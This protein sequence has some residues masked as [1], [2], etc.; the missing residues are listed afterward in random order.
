MEGVRKKLFS[1]QA[2]HLGIIFSMMMSFL[3]PAVSASAY[4]N[5]FASKPEA[6]EYIVKT[7]PAK[8]I[9]S[10]SVEKQIDNLDLDIISADSNTLLVKADNIQDIQN[11]NNIKSNPDIEYI[12][13]N[14]ILKASETALD[15]EQAVQPDANTEELAAVNGGHDVIQEEDPNSG[16][17]PSETENDAIKLENNPPENE[18]PL[19]DTESTTE[20]P[21]QETSPEPSN[22][23]QD[24]QQPVEVPQEEEVIPEELPQQNT[25]NSVDTYKYD[26]WG[27][28]MVNADSAWEQLPSEG[29]SKVTI[30]VIDSGVDYNHSDL[31]GVVDQTNGKDY[32]NNDDDAMD[33]FGHG[34]HVAG[35]IAAEMNNGGIVGVAA[36]TSVKILPLKVL[37]SRGEGT[38]FNI[39]LAIKDAVDRGADIINLSLGGPGYSKTLEEAVNYAINHNVLV[40]AA[41][42]NDY[43][44][45]SYYTPA[46]LPGVLTVGSIDESQDK[47]SFSNYGEELEIVAPGERV[48]STFPAALIGNMSQDNY[49][50]ENDSYYVFEDGTSM[51]T[52]FVSGVAALLKAND[53]SLSARDIMHRLTLTANDLGSFG[54]DKEYGYGLVD[55][56]A[57]LTANTLPDPAQLTIS[58]PKQEQ[59]IWGKVDVTFEAIGLANGEAINLS[60]LKDEVT[61]KTETINYD[62]TK[63]IYN[64][65]WDT[66]LLENG[67]YTLKVESSTQ[68]GTAGPLQDSVYVEVRNETMNGLQLTVKNP[69][70]TPAA[71]AMVAVVHH[72]YWDGIGEVDGPYYPYPIDD[73]Y[74]WS[75]IVYDG[76]TDQY[77]HVRIPGA[78]ATDGN[79][80]EV[81]VLS[82]DDN[83]IPV[84]YHKVLEGPT[85]Q[86]IDGSN[87][88]KV[89]FNVEDRATNPIQ[90]ADIILTFEKGK[91]IAG[92]PIPIGMTND[93]GEL[94]A[95]IEKDSYVFET[96]TEQAEDGNMYILKTPVTEIGA[97]EQENQDITFDSQST[98]ELNVDLSDESYTSVDMY[99]DHEGYGLT[100][101]KTNSTKVFVSEG[102]YYPSLDLNVQD[103]DRNW[104]YYFDRKEPVVVQKNE[105]VTLQVGGSLESEIAVSSDDPEEIEIGDELYRETAIVDQY[106]N[107]LY[108]EE[109]A[110]NVEETT[111]FS[112]L[113]YIGKDKKRHYLKWDP[114]SN[115]AKGVLTS[116][117]YQDWVDYEP[118]LVITKDGEEL[119]RFNDFDLHDSL[120][121]DTDYLNL[122]VGDYKAHFEL[123]AG[124]LGD[125]ISNEVA[126]NVVDGSTPPSTTKT[127]NIIDVDGNNASYAGVSIIKWQT[128]S[129]HDEYGVT[130]NQPNEQHGYYYPVLNTN[131]DEKGNVEIPENIFMDGETYYLL[132]DHY[133]L[134]NEHELF[135]KKVTSLDGFDSI[136]LQ[137][138]LVPVSLIAKDQ[139]QDLVGH[140]AVSFP[141]EE[142]RPITTRSASYL[143]NGAGQIWLTKDQSYNFLFENSYVY[144]YSQPGPIYYLSLKNELITGEKTVTFEGENTVAIDGDFST[145]NNKVIGKR[146][147]LF[148]PIHNYGIGYNMV[149]NKTINV[150]PGTYNLSLN[151]TIEDKEGI[152]G[153]WFDN[154]QQQVND[155][156]TL[157]V[158]DMFTANLS[159]KGQT[160]KP[161][162]ELQGE[163]NFSD[164]YGNRLGEIWKDPIGFDEDYYVLKQTN[165]ISF[166]D[167]KTGE[168]IEPLK[169]QYYSPDDVRPIFN[170]YTPTGKKIAHYPVWYYGYIYEPINDTFAAG[171]H[172]AEIVLAVGPQGV[173]KAEQAFE[174]VTTKVTINE[175][176]LESYTNKTTVQVTGTAPAGTNVDIMNGTKVLTSVKADSEGYFK[177]SVNLGK[178]GIYEIFAKA[179]G[180]ASN[181]VTVH[182]DLTAPSAATVTTSQANNRVQLTWSNTSQDVVKYNIYRMVDGKET[183]IAE[184]LPVTTTQHSDKTVEPGKTYQYVVESVD[185]AGNKTKSS[186][187]SVTTATYQIN[188]VSYTVQ[189]GSRGYAKIGTDLLFTVT[190]TTGQNVNA[191]VTFDTFESE[192]E[193]VSIPLVEEPAGTFKGNFTIMEDIKQIK[194]AKAV[195]FLVEG[196]VDIPQQEKEIFTTPIT[197]GAT[198]KGNVTMGTTTTPVTDATVYISGANDYIF[199]KVS[200]NGEFEIAGLE[201]NKTYQISVYSPTKGWASLQEDLVVTTGSKVVNIPYPLQYDVTIKVVDKDKEKPLKGVWVS[202]QKS[203]TG[204]YYYG[205]GYTNEEGIVTLWNSDETPFTKLK[206]GEYQLSTW[207]NLNYK[208]IDAELS[209]IAISGNELDIDK[210]IAL[211]SLGSGTISGTV[212][213]SGT[214]EG[215]AGATVNA[216]SWQAYNKGL[217]ASF[218]A[219]SDG[220]GNYKF[221]NLPTTTDWVVTFQKPGYKSNTKNSVQVT[222][223][224][225]TSVDMALAPSE[226]IVG[227][228]KKTDGTL[229]GGIQVTAQGPT[230]WYYATTDGQGKFTINGLEAGNYTVST[231]ISSSLGFKNASKNVTAD[232]FADNRTADVGILE[233]AEYGSIEGTVLDTKGNPL[234]YIYVYVY[235]KTSEG[236]E[237]WSQSART[238][239]QGFFKV[240]GL[241]SGKS[242]IVKT[243]NYQGYID[244][245]QEAK[246]TDVVTFV[247][248][249]EAQLNSAFSGEGNGWTVDRTVA[250]P[251]NEIEYTLSYKNNSGVDIEGVNAVF[252]LDSNST[253]TANSMLVNGA[254]G[255]VTTEGNK[256]TVNLGNI[257][258]DGKGVIRFKATIDS[259]LAKDI[260][261]VGNASLTWGGKKVELSPAATQ[262]VLTTINAP[263]IVTTTDETGKIP[264]T[265]YGKAAS[266]SVVSVYDGDKVLGQAAVSGRWWSLQVYLDANSEN[267]EHYLFAQVTKGEMKHSSETITVTY[268]PD[269]PKVTELEVDAGWNGKVKPNPYNDL[270]TFAITE[271]YAIPVKLVFDDN[272]KVS[273]VKISFIGKE[274]NLTL[275][276]GYYTGQVPYGW[277]GFGEHVIELHFTFNGEVYTLPIMEV[278]VLIDPSGYV[279]EGARENRLEGVTSIIEQ[280]VDDTNND[281]RDGKWLQWDAARFGQI[282][283]Q[284]TDKEGKY[285]WDVPQGE[286]RVIF[287]KDGYEKVVSETVNVPPPETQLNVGLFSLAKPEVKQ[288]TPSDAATNIAVST[289]INI[290]FSQLMDEST[291]S[292]D[293][294]ILTNKATE[295]VVAGGTIEGKDGYAGYSTSSSSNPG[296]PTG[297]TLSKTFTYTPSAALQPNTEYE[298]TIRG[299]VKNYNNKQLGEDYSWS[300]K[301]AA[302]SDSGTPTNPPSGG[303]PGGGGP[304]KQPELQVDLK[305]IIQT[306]AKDIK[307]TIAAEK[308]QQGIQ[309]DAE[310]I[311]QLKAKEKN[312]I[313]ESDQYLIHIPSASVPKLGEKSNLQLKIEAK[314][315]LKGQNSA[316]YKGVSNIF[317]FS[318]AVKSESDTK[319]ITEF[320]Q[321]IKI[322]VKLNKDQ[323]KNTNVDLLGAYYIGKNGLEYM[324]GTFSLTTQMYEFETPHFSEFVIAEYKKQFE[325]VPQSFWGYSDIQFM[326]SRKLVAG[327]TTSEFKPTENVTRAQFAVLLA[328]VLDLPSVEQSASSFKDISNVDW[329]YSDVV[330]ASK[331]GLIKGY[332]SGEFK[333]NAYISRQE[334]AVMLK[335]ALDQKGVEANTVN[336]D[337][338]AKFA[339]KANIQDWAMADVATVVEIGL[340]GGRSADQFAPQQTATR[341]EATTLLK[342]LY[343]QK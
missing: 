294:I 308:L 95:F 307:L 288:V 71:N 318:L 296:G 136:N 16:A 281:I 338:L 127:V 320:D 47:S 204:E 187:V 33:D 78:Y 85:E 46:A 170:I 144:D 4:G 39:S 159:L 120:I 111:S 208:E 327:I 117:Y 282:N 237:I 335:R 272:S 293:S 20:E 2:I 119:Q 337:I 285:G 273:N 216:W 171:Q 261:I 38:V 5:N 309:F 278:L 269:V 195:A 60:I 48:L 73:E 324:G 132:I 276:D 270:L 49:Y 189:K 292:A 150:T 75:D 138:E 322:Q 57:A 147:V 180:E 53:K 312:L 231:S 315:D 26:Q 264:V 108:E 58:S 12:E 298:V 155:D 68:T 267:A 334:M 37:D 317:D 154:N 91:R 123:A 22:G 191:V 297:K 188:K 104:F 295:E 233:V 31:D 166:V 173:V 162:E 175:P 56:Y 205:S 54:F 316:G 265:V 198:I 257:A 97:T 67:M 225:T 80:Y 65:E 69:D 250:V 340:I 331:Y 134:D 254:A 66:S 6:T 283:P 83:S 15:S 326:A 109:Y 333:P 218:G 244:Q 98:G 153:Y 287:T 52:P 255:A 21:Q 62:N 200:E 263:S 113:S 194:S 174:V 202:L 72:G 300:F 217:N 321:P 131:T 28:A 280:Y 81:Y 258:K 124:P 41:A 29:L 289:N 305:P 148:D 330:T 50:Q 227:Y 238:D 268:N 112:K 121:I 40:I 197:I 101:D 172:K 179:S 219:V 193:T 51:A 177:A 248:T 133:N 18:V 199:V 88:Q 291:V 25:E 214:N 232:Q 230:G 245:A 243:S 303:S 30:A 183:L 11:L 7:K 301:T 102:E 82:Y 105:V 89:T 125:V 207:N 10:L 323:L 161:G 239:T 192:N 319:A 63:S 304:A 9:S 252:E 76:S 246:V 74:Y 302:A 149:E 314:G 100:F 44:D 290:E 235:E 275:K 167:K 249:N 279:F 234:N 135:W 103:R 310:S 32:V 129:S 87:A 35:I 271:T 42:G 23:Q 306:T 182:V 142:G 151:Y 70:G 14:L 126:F 79:E 45:V 24:N 110:T 1:K 94:T 145:I 106:D 332:E 313:V 341:A 27:L 343:L 209:T 19:Q 116:L 130:T 86:V 215:I 247:L 342:R 220:D 190:A 178:E 90:N 77:G 236:K 160:L 114:S 186:P 157:S 176:S 274:Y 152:W 17:N 128:Y 34:T 156:T 226:Q 137:E 140:V 59:Q 260:T 329:Y 336:E 277:R 143:N 241:E 224:G 55:A 201:P 164:E 165:K 43:D 84:F 222:K 206:E 3:A 203:G 96:G 8:G 229:L 146:I 286:W 325:D 221:E 92:L 181:T 223:D 284:L 36:P 251:G 328:R 213:D 122:E 163:V 185:N 118:Q 141:N 139:E 99:L 93:K 253:Y 212:T 115:Q 196:G 61:I 299:N 240:R 228:V 259:K 266:G 262:V 339:D 64:Y 211:E 210:V 168:I 311:Q 242:Y 107:Y 184:N 158:G 256:I 169:S 13:P